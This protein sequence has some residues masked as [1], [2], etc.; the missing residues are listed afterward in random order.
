MIDI[1]FDKMYIIYL[2]INRDY[3]FFLNISQIEYKFAEFDSFFI[4]L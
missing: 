2:C 4:S 3:I 1:I